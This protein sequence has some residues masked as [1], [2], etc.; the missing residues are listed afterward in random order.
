MPTARQALQEMRRLLGILRT[1]GEGVS[2]SPQPGLD[3]LDRLLDQMRGSGLR[4]DLQVV[5]RRRALPVGL[6]LTAYRVVQ[7]SLVNVLKHAGEARATVVTRYDGA[8]LDLEVTDSG[9]PVAS[10]AVPGGTG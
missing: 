1:D 10:T 7:E 3:D 6:D 8:H 5:G 4:V 9:P 2:L